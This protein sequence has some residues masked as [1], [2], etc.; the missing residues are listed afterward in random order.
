MA[1]SAEAEVTTWKYRLTTLGL[2][3]AYSPSYLV[4][5]STLQNHLSS[6]KLLSYALPFHAYVVASYAFVTGALLLASL[7]PRFI[8]EGPL[9]VARTF[10]VFNWLPHSLLAALAIAV[11]SPQGWIP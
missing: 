3:L 7:G 6:L 1:D 2:L 5:P 10:L 9:R 8:Y 11:H 4:P